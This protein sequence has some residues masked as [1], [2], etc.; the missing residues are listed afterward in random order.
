[1]NW[2]LLVLLF[3]I[4]IEYIGVGQ[5]VPGFNSLH[6]P[7]ILSLLTVIWINS[8]GG[9]KELLKHRQTIILV[10][11]LI[12]TLASLSWAF[13]RMSVINS[14]KVQIGYLMLFCICYWVFKDYRKINVFIVFIVIIH[15][16]LVV[17][18]IDI[19]SRGER[20]GTFR[21]GYFL[22]DGNDF[23]WSL[24][25]VLP[26]AFYLI[27][28]ASGTFQRITALVATL[29]IVAGI[30]MTQSR[31]AA[32][33][34][35]ASIGYLVLTSKRKVFALVLSII[36]AVLAISFAPGSYIQRLQSIKSYEEDSSA[37][38][39]IM[40][41]KAATAMAFDHPLGVGPGNFPSIYGRFY[42]EEFSD[43]T[44]WASNRWIAPHSIYFLTLAEYGFLG[45]ILLLL[46]I[47]VN[48]RNNLLRGHSMRTEPG[49]ASTGSPLRRIVN[50]SLV[51]FAAGGFF[52][53]GFNYPHIYI[54][55]SLTIALTILESQDIDLKESKL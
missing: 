34:T 24:A 48:L 47:Y 6:I 13:I 19:M 23:S 29:S 11:F 2:T 10:C 31:G 8:K 27:S 28:R 45:L 41:W 1:M 5:Y 52:L 46:L 9:I 12:F 43:E 21:A 3:I 22:G 32:I 44:V 40:A 54:L 15:A 17:L 53:G 51:A 55:S 37:K 42:R 18:N 20:T 14:L 30:V 49:E 16:I 39:R 4:F 33:A 7:L 38:G 36:F 35:A 25:I 50:A 26:F